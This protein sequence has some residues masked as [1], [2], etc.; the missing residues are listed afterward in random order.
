MSSC[1]RKGDGKSLQDPAAV[2]RQDPTAVPREDEEPRGDDSIEILEVVGVD[3]ETGLT[4]ASTPKFSDE[5]AIPV[6]TPVPG[7]PSGSR[8]STALQE[9]IQEKEKYYDLLLRKQAE[10]D[11]F[12]KRSDKDR[13]E[14]RGKAFADLFGAIVPV[15]DNLE[16]A[17]R[18]SEGSD[19]PLRQGVMMIHQQLMDV[20]VKEG[21]QPLDTTG[22]RFDPH[23]H[24]AVE[25]VDVAGFEQGVI[26]EEMRKGYIFK[27]NLI[28]AAMVR[29]ASGRDPKGDDGGSPETF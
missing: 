5:T 9:A 13:R 23:L 7:S 26:L 19:D 25:V 11:N 14:A 20:L 17:L 21:L 29:V 1:G 18:T 24:E 16:R 8:S 4:E 2:A 6:P 12:R 27:D 15:L 22:A 3:E 10:F 28:R